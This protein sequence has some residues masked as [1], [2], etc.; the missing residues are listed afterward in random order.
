MSDDVQTPLND[1]ELEIMQPIYTSEPA[2]VPAVGDGGEFQTFK[3]PSVY[4]PY[5]Q[6]D[7]I[8]SLSVYGS[9][10]GVSA[11]RVNGRDYTLPIPKPLTPGNV[12]QSKV[13]SV[14]DKKIV[15]DQ[16][17]DIKYSGEQST[18]GTSRRFYIGFPSSELPQTL[19]TVIG[20]VRSNRLPA[21]SSATTFSSD[22]EGVSIQND[23]LVS[24][25]QFRVHGCKTLEEIKA[26]L[27][28]K[29][30]IV[31]YQSTAY[32]GTNGLTVSVSDY[33]W[34]FAVADGVVNKAYVR[35]LYWNF[36]NGCAPG[37]KKNSD[38]KSNLPGAKF[39][40]SNADSFVYTMPEL[41]PAF[42][43]VADLNE[44][45]VEQNEAGKPVVVRYPLATPEAYANDPVDIFTDDGELWVDGG[46][47]V[48]VAVN[49]IV[50]NGMTNDERAGE[51]GTPQIHT[52]P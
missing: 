44:Y 14:W 39:V 38:C 51:Y 33:S 5:V 18:I 3:K 9:V 21:A 10:A 46:D 32:D 40:T 1:G 25:I 43:T 27:A 35:S 48:E 23:S 47:F 7:S 11:V 26:W 12:W 13:N 20:N 42:K 36:P 22:Y 31:Y 6:Y 37:S 45:L 17:S 52:F 19:G 50:I 34:G 16:N 28:D 41:A 29:P 15:I 49:N 24:A 2:R 8:E 30:L 4:V